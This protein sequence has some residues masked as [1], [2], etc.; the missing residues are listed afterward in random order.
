MCDVCGSRWK[1][2]A[3]ISLHVVTHLPQDEQPYHCQKCNKGFTQYSN[4]KIHELVH[5]DQ[6]PFQCDLCS[7]TFAIKPRLLSH[8][9]TSHVISLFKCHQCRYAGKTLSA[10]KHHKRF[11]DLPVKC[12][13]CDKRFS[14]NSVVKKHLKTHDLPSEFVC[15]CGKTFAS[16]GAFKI[17]KVRKH[18][19]EPDGN[20]RYKC[21]TCDYSTSTLQMLSIHEASH[22]K[23]F[24]CHNCTKTF[25]FEKQLQSHLSW[26]PTS[27][28][29][30]FN[31]RDYT[32]KVCGRQER[33]AWGLKNHSRIHAER[34]QCQICKKDYSAAVIKSHILSHKT[35]FQCDLCGICSKSKEKLHDHLKLHLSSS[36]H[37]CEKCC[38]VFKS[39]CSFNKHFKKEHS[40]VSKKYQCKVCG[41]ET[42]NYWSLK[43]HLLVHAKKVQ[44]PICKK[45]CSQTTIKTHIES[46]KNKFHCDL[47]GISSNSKDFLEKH[48]KIHLSPDSQVCKICF[49]VFKYKPSLNRHLKNVHK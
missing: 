8:M 25:A 40:R 32:C 48:L 3:S 2:K 4:L 9:Q 29:S 43:M 6:K 38:K 13:K 45:N 34:V 23:M 41:K 18:K 36:S 16:L 12:P 30:C 5:V 37:K 44:C 1:G 7:K 28:Y 21:K 22:T 11:H 17:H 20:K 47:C 35:K 27:I 15:H 33:D 14:K 49:R 24:K 42:K 39:R 19:E 26:E 31:N 46:H 10:L